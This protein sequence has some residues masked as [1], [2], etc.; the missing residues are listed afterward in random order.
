MLVR[1]RENSSITKKKT[2]FKAGWNE[3][4]TDPH[5]LKHARKKQ[6]ANAAPWYLNPLP[7]IQS[8]NTD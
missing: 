4:L 3:T 2:G 7:G 6:V 1:G 5:Y 8:L